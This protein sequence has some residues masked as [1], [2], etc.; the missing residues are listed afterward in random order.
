MKKIAIALL[1]FQII[2]SCNGQDA[3]NTYTQKLEFGLKGPIKEVT[4]YLCRS[5]DGNT[6]IDT[7]KSIAKIVMKFDTLGDVT[8]ID[9]K[10]DFGESGN[11]KYLS[12]FSGKGKNLSFKE[13][14]RIGEGEIH[15]TNYKYVWSD[16]YNY[17]II[18]PEDDEYITDVTLDE[19]YRLIKSTFKIDNRTQSIEEFDIK[20]END[21]IKEVKTKVTANNGGKQE[22]TE[23]IQ[24][25]QEYDHHGNP[26]VLYVYNDL[27]EQIKHV[28]Y[29]RYKY[30]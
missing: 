12:V 24:V 23:Q 30:Y 17:K 25:V 11:S 18:A 28:L 4:S 1:P 21:K 13:T 16:D 19:N 22:V 20:I 2:L 9:K 15:E 5:K 14:S 29:K 26:T 6:Q 10:W 7:T 27:N 8:T 3:K